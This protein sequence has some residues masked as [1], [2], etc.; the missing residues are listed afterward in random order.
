[1]PL[2]SRLIINGRPYCRKEYL[3]LWMLISYVLYLFCIFCSI[4]NGNVEIRL[5]LV[6]RNSGFNPE[7]LLL[8]SA[9]KECN[10]WHLQIFSIQ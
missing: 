9:A 10:M 6:S 1:M 7:S 2:V 8:P 3:G 5:S 4:T